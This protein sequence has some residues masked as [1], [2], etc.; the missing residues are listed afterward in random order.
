MQVSSGFVYT[1]LSAHGPAYNAAVPIQVRLYCCVVD[2]PHTAYHHPAVGEFIE[3]P[4]P[5][6]QY[7]GRIQPVSGCQVP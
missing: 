2:F 4:Y 5:L 6:F 7:F 1:H 3:E